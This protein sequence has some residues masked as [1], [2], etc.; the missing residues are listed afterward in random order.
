[1]VAGRDRPTLRE[2]DGGVTAHEAWLLGGPVDGRF[3]PIEV[4]PDG[5][6]PE[7]TRLPPAGLFV[8]VNDAP[9]PIVEHVY[10]RV[11]KPDLP[12]L[13]RYRETD[14]FA[15]VE[16]KHHSG[17]LTRSKGGSLMNVVSAGAVS[18][19]ASVACL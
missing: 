16:G 15:L 5:R 13:Y 19:G 18:S 17:R 2:Q 11:H 12:L 1:M 6:L 10:L 7:S 9:A 8:G 4:D 3:M 14:E